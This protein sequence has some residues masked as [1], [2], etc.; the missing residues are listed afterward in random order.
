[1]T[2][3]QNTAVQEKTTGKLWD[4]EKGVWKDNKAACPVNGV[5]STHEMNGSSKERFPSP[6]WIFGYG[7]LCWKAGDINYAEKRI[8]ILKGWKRRF[9]QR[10]CDH[11]G[12]P[13]SPG[14]KTLSLSLLF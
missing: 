8:A 4:D 2:T 9:Y 5:S 13:D 12:T 3:Q 6:L 11:R 1:M 14:C 7:S 10:S